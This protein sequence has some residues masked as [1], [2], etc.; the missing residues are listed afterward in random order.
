M[1]NRTVTAL[2]I[3]LETKRVR[4]YYVG[5]GGE[6]EGNIDVDLPSRDVRVQDLVDIA[7]NADS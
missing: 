2:H 4:A 1:Q 5:K 3:N 6:D 7:L